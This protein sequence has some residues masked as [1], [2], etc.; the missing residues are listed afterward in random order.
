M[1]SKRFASPDLVEL[2]FDSWRGVTVNNFFMSIALAE[3]LFTKRYN[4]NGYNV[5]QQTKSHVNFFCTP[6]GKGTKA[7]LG[8]KKYSKIFGIT[9]N[10][11]P[12][13]LNLKKCDSDIQGDLW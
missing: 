6:N 4:S 9:N 10:M 13:F 12:D 1:P 11:D 7:L 2:C 3:E 8:K 5:L